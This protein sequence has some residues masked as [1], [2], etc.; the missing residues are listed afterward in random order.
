MCFQFKFFL[1]FPIANFMLNNW[2]VAEL[3]GWINYRLILHWLVPSASLAISCPMSVWLSVC[4]VTP[5]Y[6]LEFEVQYIYRTGNIGKDFIE[7]VLAIKL[8]I[9]LFLLTY[10]SYYSYSIILLL[11]YIIISYY[12]IILIIPIN[13]L[14]FVVLC[15]TI[16]YK[17]LFV[18][19]TALQWA[20]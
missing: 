20:A 3:R 19:T 1:Y 14:F 6:V 11:F 15:Q 12:S 7:L 5:G 2:T 10:Y 8:I 4:P 18:L 16:T 9:I 13:L 17:L